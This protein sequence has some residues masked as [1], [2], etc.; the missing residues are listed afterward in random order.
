MP[1]EPNYSEIHRVHLSK[2]QK[3]WLRSEALRRGLAVS[4]L[5][6]EMVVTA[7]NASDGAQRGAA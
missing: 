3:D 4:T 1:A 2:S 7:M 5:L 6:R